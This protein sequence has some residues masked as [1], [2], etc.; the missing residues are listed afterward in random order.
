[1]SGQQIFW[2]KTQF[3]HRKG[4]TRATWHHPSDGRAVTWTPEVRDSQRGWQ[5]NV[6]GSKTRPHSEECWKKNLVFKN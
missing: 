5:A 1:M 4:F 6:R 2:L 3:P